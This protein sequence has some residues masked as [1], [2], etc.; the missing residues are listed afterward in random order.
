MSDYG[1]PLY[2]DLQYCKRCCMPETNEGIKFDEMGI[3]QACQSTEQKMHINW[4]EREKELRKIFEQYKKNK[5]G[6]YDCI[7]GISGGKDST[8][9]FKDLERQ[10]YDAQYILN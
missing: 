10:H 3:C 8:F 7:I 5:K 6:P 1:K 4:A 9:H 2:P